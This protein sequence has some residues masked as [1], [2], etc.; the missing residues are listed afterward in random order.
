MAFDWNGYLTLAKS[1]KTETDGHAASTDIEARRRS[2]ISRAYYAMY[3][4]AVVYAKSNLGYSPATTG[5]NQGHSEIQGVYRRQFGS[6]QL[7]EIKTIL[8]RLH[9]ARKDCDYEDRDLGDLQALLGS[10]ILDAERM[11]TILTP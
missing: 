5:P 10:I 4:L 9:K 1:L 3:H 11:K 2:A 6:V 7:Q 8:Y